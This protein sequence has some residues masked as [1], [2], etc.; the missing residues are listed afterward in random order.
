MT[1]AH[2]PA[3]FAVV[4]VASLAPADVLALRVDTARRFQTMDNFGA[5]G[6]WV[7]DHVGAEWSLA[8]R[9]RVADLLFSRERGIGLSLWRFNPGAGSLATDQQWDPWRGVECFQAAPNAPCDW[10]R[11][12]GQQWFLRAAKKRGVEHLLA[13]FYSPPTWLTVNGHAHG[14]AQTNSTNLKPGAEPRFARF[15]ADILEHFAHEGLAFDYVSP[16]NEPNWAWDQYGQE[17]CRYSND[18]LKRLLEAVHRELRRRGLRT[19]LEAV[20]AGEIV[21]MLDDAVYRE[22]AGTGD[23]GAAHLAGNRSL[24]KGRYGQY[25]GA[26]LGDPAMRRILGGRI[27]AHSYWTDRDPRHLRELRQALRRNIDTYMPGGRYWQ[28][29][30]CVMEHGRDLGM[31]TALR[32]ARVIH[33]DLTAANASSWQWW[34]ALSPHDYKDGLLFTDY[35]QTGEQNVLTS[36]TFWTLGNWSRYVRPGA[37]RVALEPSETEGGL[38]A[39]A[40]ISA[41]GKECLAVLVNDALTELRVALVPTAPKLRWTRYETSGARDLARR[42]AVR[43]GHPFALPARSVTTLVAFLP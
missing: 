9:E 27:G 1:S 32:V 40:F 36:K 33:Y 34:L 14:D 3:V 12:A 6:A 15:I 29:E 21:A 42:P 11:Q 39:S 17:G 25:V 30:Y 8:A 20:E 5:S 19:G 7:M 38:L 2:L 23:P 37:W 28:T 35:R 10:T 13:C 16:A 31:D 43:S 26:F 22:F 41:S 4:A 18:D 24:G